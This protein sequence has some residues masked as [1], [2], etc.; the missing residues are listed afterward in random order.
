MLT[1]QKFDK[2]RYDHLVA[3]LAAGAFVAGDRHSGKTS[4]ILEVVKAVG[5]HKCVVIVPYSTMIWHTQ[6]RWKAMFGEAIPAP[7]IIS[8]SVA[9]D[10]LRGSSKLIFC[11][12]WFLCVKVMPEMG[13]MVWRH[14]VRGATL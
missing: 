6:L 10:A 7:Q 3:G 9:M 5:A 12:E 13:E 14:Q 2:R 8:A 1:T 4:A 11:D